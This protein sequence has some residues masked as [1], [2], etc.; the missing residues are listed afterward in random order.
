MPTVTFTRT[1]CPSVLGYINIYVAVNYT[2]SYNISTNQTTVN[3]TSVQIKNGSYNIGTVVIKGSVKI[4][5]TVI[6]SFSPGESAST[7]VNLKTTYETIPGSTGSAVV[8]HNSDGTGSFTLTLDEAVSAIVAFQGIFGYRDS[9]Y[10]VGIQT[11][12]NQTVNLT[13]RPRTSSV[14]AT[15]AYFGSAVTISISRYSSTFKHTV[16]ASCAGRSETVMTKGTSTSPTWTPTV[17]NFAP[18]IT[19]AMSATATITCYTYSGDTLV[20]QSSTTCTLTFRAADVAPTLSIATAD[21]TGNL[22]TFG[23]YVKSKSKITVTLTPTL[24]YGASLVQTSISANGASYTSSPATTDFIASTSYTSVSATIKDSRGQS[25][26]ASASIQIYDYAAPKINSFSVVRCDSGGHTYDSGAFIKC[27]YNVTISPLDGNTSHQPRSL[28]FKYK[29]RG[30]SSYTSVTISLSAYSQSGS[31]SPIA[32]DTNST[33]NTLL[34]LTDAFSASQVAQDAPAAFSHIN[35][36]AGHNGGVAV[37]KVSEYD[38]TLELAGDWGFKRG[39]KDVSNAFKFS[40]AFA[41]SHTITVPSVSAHLLLLYGGATS[42]YAVV[43]APCTS[44]GVVDH[45][46]ISAG[47]GITITRG[48][49]T[50][51]VAFSSSRALQITD[52]VVFGDACSV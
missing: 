20:G 29:K 31:T 10:K 52:I 40:T 22:A 30:D 12:S 50:L 19:T 1:N 4:N 11:P 23:K 33:Y 32:A 26:S 15:N 44:G 6:C 18:R 17:A 38:K 43:F 34:V 21:P 35:H 8:N 47:T 9:S 28:V 24:K 5:G 13:P 37:G 7:Q 49:N 45:T 48:T 41:T 16:V 27:T 14:S 36:G 2:E 46:V 51:T 3:I 42:T 25:V 39:G